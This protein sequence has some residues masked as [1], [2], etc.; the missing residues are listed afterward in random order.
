M[1]NLQNLM[2][3]KRSRQNFTKWSW[4]KIGLDDILWAAGAI[5]TA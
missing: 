5:Q 2:A 3:V 1:G 4:S